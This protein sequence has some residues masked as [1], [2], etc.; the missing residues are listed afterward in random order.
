MDSVVIRRAEMKDISAL[1]DLYYKWMKEGLV[2]TT[3]FEWDP[4]KATMLVL[5]ALQGGAYFLAEDGDRTVGAIGVMLDRWMENDYSILKEVYYWID[6]EYRGKGVGD[7]LLVAV[8]DLGRQSKCAIVMM[9]DWRPG[10]PY[11]LE[12][13]Y[14]SR[15]YA[16]VQ[17]QYWKWL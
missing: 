13:Y 12:N 7:R 15:G 11:S 17:M 1:V 3:G 4:N 10:G 8:E 14:Q 2:D 6:P 16:P 5:K 9:Y